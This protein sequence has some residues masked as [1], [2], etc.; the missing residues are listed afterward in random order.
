M[1]IGYESQGITSAKERGT[2]KEEAGE[3]C[4]CKQV[5]RIWGGGGEGERGEDGRGEKKERRR[6]S[7][8]QK[9]T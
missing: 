4:C 7:L 1:L 6:I 9:L 8:S 3:V 5:G 2:E